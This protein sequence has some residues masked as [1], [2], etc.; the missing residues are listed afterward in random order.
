MRPI[1]HIRTHIFCVSQAA[2]A[3]IAGTSQPTVSRWERGE[4]DPGLEEML[5]IRAAAQERAIEWNDS[6]FF[7]GRSE[8]ERAAS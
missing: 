8:P 6:W 7:S 3:A 4:L 2:F 1:E 5:R